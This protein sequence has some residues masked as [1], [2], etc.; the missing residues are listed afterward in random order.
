[1]ATLGCTEKGKKEWQAGVVVGLLPFR[2]SCSFS[3]ISQG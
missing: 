2:E 1:M 3:H